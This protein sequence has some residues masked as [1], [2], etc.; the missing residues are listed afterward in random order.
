MVHYVSVNVYRQ[1]LDSGIL[2]QKRQRVYDIFFSNQIPMTGA[3][4][5][6]KY[7]Q[8]YPSAEHSET[9]RNRITELKAQGLVQEVGTTTCTKTQRQVSSF[10]ITNSVGEPFTRKKTKSEKINEAIS[11]LKALH[12][13]INE[14]T[15]PSEYKDGISA[16]IAILMDN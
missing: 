1:V 3:E 15:T 11:Q 8:A 4:V 9:I 5:A 16:C 7:K 14:T 10:I 2:S 13:G 12:Q 6:E